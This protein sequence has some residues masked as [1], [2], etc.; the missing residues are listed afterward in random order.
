MGTEGARK[1]RLCRR[2][3]RAD[4]MGYALLLAAIGVTLLFHAWRERFSDNLRDAR[5]LAACALAAMAGS[6]TVLLT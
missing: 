6:A 1:Q 3:G 5:L 2:V 4:M